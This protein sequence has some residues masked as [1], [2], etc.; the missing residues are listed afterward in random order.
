MNRTTYILVELRLRYLIRRWKQLTK[1]PFSVSWFARDI[2]VV[3][4]MSQKP[5]SSMS[6]IKDIY[7]YA[8]IKEEML[9][10]LIFLKKKK[11]KSTPL[12]YL[13]PWWYCCGCVGLITS[14]MLT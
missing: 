4:N 14:R 3:R 1:A 7:S 11:K 9:R 8:T 13:P 10:P 5:S 2:V 12:P 6:S